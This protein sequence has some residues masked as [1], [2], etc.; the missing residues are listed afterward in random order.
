MSDQAPPR[1]NSADEEALTMPN[2]R[3]RRRSRWI[4]LAKLSA[5]A[6]I[7][8]WLFRIRL[9]DIEPVEFL[10]AQPWLLLTLLLMTW[11]TF[12][13]CALRWQL[14]LRT[15]D[16]RLNLHDIFRVV[17]LASFAG[18]F[19]PGTVGGDILRV[20]LGNRMSSRGM[21]VITMTVVMDRLLGISALLALGWAASS[22]LIV[23]IPGHSGMKQLSLLILLLFS[24]V[25]MLIAGLPWAARALNDRKDSEKPALGRGSL[26]TLLQ[27]LKPGV[28]KRVGLPSLIAAWVLS[29]AIQGKDLLILFLIAEATGF[30]ELGIWGNAVAGSLAFLS[31][32]LPLTPGGLGISE[33]TFGQTAQLFRADPGHASYGSIML[34]FRLLTSL[35]VLPALLLLPRSVRSDAANIDDRDRS[36]PA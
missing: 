36:S 6:A 22:F 20:V 18:L 5:A 7:L 25:I 35:T 15:Q 4:A 10:F 31:Q 12:P 29:L 34:A 14:L 23:T 1:P 27:A 28:L 3:A 21:A 11:L 30:G 32:V 13:L 17:Y 2:E 16:I 8:Y 19:L 26:G 33:A 9:I 24:C